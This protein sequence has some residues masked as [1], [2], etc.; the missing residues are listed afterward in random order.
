MYLQMVCVSDGEDDAVAIV[1]VRARSDLMNQFV[2]CFFDFC[3]M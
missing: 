3:Q 2:H 1:D